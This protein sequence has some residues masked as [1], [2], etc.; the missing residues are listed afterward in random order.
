MPT[1]PLNIPS[2]LVRFTSLLSF[3]DLLPVSVFRLLSLLFVTALNFAL[4]SNSVTQKLWMKTNCFFHSPL[5]TSIGYL[6]TG[7]HKHFPT[8]LK[9]SFSDKSDLANKVLNPQEKYEL[10]CY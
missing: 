9:N 8:F 3:E 1:L 7:Q 2:S 5:A 6:K 10:S 4:S